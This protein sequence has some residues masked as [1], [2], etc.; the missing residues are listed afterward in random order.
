MDVLKVLD[1]LDQMKVF[2]EPIYSADEHSIAAYE[3]IGT[4]E[5]EQFDLNTFS[6]SEEVPEDIRVEIEQL[7]IRQALQTAVQ[8]LAEVDIYI[9]CNPNLLMLDF[10]ESYF[11]ILKEMVQD[12]LLSHITLVIAEHKFEGNIKQL[13]HVIKYMKTYGIK[14]ALDDIGPHSNLDHMILLEP[15]VLKINVEQLNYNQWGPQNH[16]FTTLRSLALKIGASLMVS[17]V[18]TVYQL[19]HGWKSGARYYKGP[20]LERPAKDFILRDTLKSRFQDECKQF[21]A[22]EKK[23]VQQKYEAMKTL[24]KKITTAV[25]QIDPTS[26]NTNTLLTLAERLRPYIFRLYICDGEGFQTTPNIMLK[27]GRWEVQQEA[28]RKNW[29]W[30]PYF[31]LN[32]IKMRHDQQGEFSSTY[33]DIETEELTRTYSMA[34]PKNEYLFVDISYEYLYEHNIVN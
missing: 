31:L 12:E 7:V 16:V 26:K 17:G 34:L 11:S 19:Q 20:Y 23:L 9:P 10:G 21:I 27:E 3:V 14:I 32:L 18:N 5:G 28:F 8:G 24:E 13:H 2:F 6:Y 25:E 4:I 1:N 15:Y 29:S 33:S 22:T 30:R